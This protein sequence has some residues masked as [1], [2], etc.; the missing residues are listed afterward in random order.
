ML[1][2]SDNTMKL[3]GGGTDDTGGRGQAIQSRSQDDAAVGYVFQRHA[4]DPEFTQ[5]AQKQHRWASGDDSIMDVS[6]SRMENGQ[7]FRTA[8]LISHCINVF[9]LFTCRTNGSTMAAVV[10]VPV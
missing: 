2:L 6:I 4:H 8:S 7:H 1:V 3:L 10:A 5:F 9:P